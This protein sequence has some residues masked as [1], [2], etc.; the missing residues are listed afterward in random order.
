MEHNL[1][2]IDMDGRQFCARCGTADSDELSRP[3][4]AMG[5]GEIYQRKSAICPACDG[6]GQ[7][8]FNCALNK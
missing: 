2:V 1:E 8:H 4:P 5:D 7:H 6:I 3:C